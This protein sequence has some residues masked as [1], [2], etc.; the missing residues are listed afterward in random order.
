MTERSTPLAFQRRGPGSFQQVASFKLSGSA[1]R[2]ISI[3][4]ITLFLISASAFIALALATGK[5]DPVIMQGS[6]R[7]GIWE[8]VAGLAAFPAT[9][10]LH[11]LLHGLAM[12]LGGARPQY[13][14]LPAHLMFYATAPGYAFRRNTCLMVEMA[15]LVVLSFLAI[16]GMF[17]LQGTIWVPLLIVCAAMNFGGAAADLWMISKTLRYST[18]S[19]I[20]NERDGFR[21][22]IREEQE[23]S[24]NAYVLISQ[25]IAYTIHQEGGVR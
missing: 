15:P 4:A 6:F 13:G 18:T 8:A 20:V 11:E 14:V 12:R 17:I 22:L 7:V 9:I 5:F 24:A 16:L 1:A 21:V 23:I 19:Y 3:L 2:G 10:V 25:T